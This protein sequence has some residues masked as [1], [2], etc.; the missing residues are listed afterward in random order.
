MNTPS[1]HR[2]HPRRA[3][4]L[5]PAA[6]LALT[7]ALGLT[8]CGGGG[9]ASSGGGTAD[10][11]GTAGQ[12]TVKANPPYGPDHMMSTAMT[13]FADA[14]TKESNGQ[15]VFDHFF[16]DSLV[17]QPD[18]ATSLDSGVIDLGYLGMA[19]TPASFPL[20]AWASKIGYGSDERPVVGLLAN[21]AAITEW[22]S[23]VPGLSDEL[24]QAGVYPIIT[25][26]QNHDSYQLLC[27]EP[28]ESLADAQGK[29][30]RVGGELYSQ[31][32]EALGMTPVTL[33]GA[34]I[35]EGFERGIV[36]CFAGAEPDMTGLGLWEVGKNLTRVNFPGW[37]SISL[38]SSTEFVDSL[39]AEQRAAFVENRAAFMEIY[40]EGYFD[41]QKRFYQ[42]EEAMD[43]TVS[44][45]APDLQQAIDGHFAEV[46]Q[47]M[48]A[49]APAGVE[50]PHEAVARFQELREKWTQIVIDLGYDK[51]YSS[52]SEWAKALGEDSVELG[53][54]AQ[55]LDEE[56]FSR[57]S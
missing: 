45:P 23:T 26:F 21:A 29:R 43:L 52:H 56:I 54:W 44:E 34:E 57:Q 37:N 2:T 30:V 5:V 7:A 18:V 19:Y 3:R 24:E 32:V 28:I 36:D 22:A 13:Q 8:A 48:I 50:N 55:K 38:A 1:D 42:E 9:M 11:A 4:S 17:S 10:A 51:G 20:D 40:Y 31:A 15:L 6:A 27:K 16:A 12:T 14:V 35:Y 47:D 46:Q 49:N 41:E 25:R 39:T 33:S 53:P